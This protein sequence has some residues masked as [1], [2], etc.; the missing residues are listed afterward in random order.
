M[1]FA[2]IIILISGCRQEKPP[3][4]DK[5]TDRSRFVRHNAINYYCRGTAPSAEVVSALIK[6]LSI[7]ELSWNNWDKVVGF[8]INNGGESGKAAALKAL[9]NEQSELHW[10][11]LKSCIP[12][13]DS[14]L[15]AIMQKLFYTMSAYGRKSIGNIYASWGEQ[16]V[17][18]LNT[19]LQS[20]VDG[21]K[22]L[23]E[24]LGKNRF[25]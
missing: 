23:L 13:Y 22:I 20:G 11:S 9:D 25:G 1:I 5:L 17:K 8:L 24:A 12:S 19:L 6:V 14:E 4:L 2:F 3:G 15:D 16:G 21:R 18:G 10:D 7:K